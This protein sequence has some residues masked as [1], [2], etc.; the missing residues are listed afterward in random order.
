MINIKEDEKLSVLNHSCA[1]LLAHAV[2]NLYPNAMF[3]VGP[4]I[5]EG[6]Y[7]DIDLGD[8]VIKE[9]DLASIEKEMKKIVKSDK[10]I[11]RIELTK[12]AALETFKEDIYKL[13]L[14]NNL[15]DNLIT[16]YKQ[17]NFID[18]CRGPHVNT[19]K[20]LK[21]FKLLKVSG[22]YYKADSNNKMLQRIYGVCFETSEELEKH[23]QEL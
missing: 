12:E 15:E 16:A 4:V 20:M 1:H 3:W 18:L 5:E 21:N 2:K 7:Y 19:T 14:I 22:A 6:F 9:E 8:N 23:L 13:D 17:D 11:K 10:L